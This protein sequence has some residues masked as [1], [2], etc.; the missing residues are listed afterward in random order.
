MDS[1]CGT[2]GCWMFLDQGCLWISWE[3][4]FKF[5]EE[6]QLDSEWSLNAG[7]WL[8]VSCSAFFHGQIPWRYVPEL[9]TMPTKYIHEPWL[10]PATLQKASNCVIG[11][12]Y[13]E[14]LC[15]HIERREVCLQRL[16]D[17]CLQIKGT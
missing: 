7:N 2:S 3:E 10:A 12:D 14:R 16:K 17:V 8:W 1:P 5:F 13:P 4:G 11:L 15:D 6:L 9:K